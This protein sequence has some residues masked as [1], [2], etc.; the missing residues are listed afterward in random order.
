MQEE[1]ATKKVRQSKK[2]EKKKQEERRRYECERVING[3]TLLLSVSVACAC[4]QS[5]D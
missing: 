3:A 5:V 1:E 4:D 2:K